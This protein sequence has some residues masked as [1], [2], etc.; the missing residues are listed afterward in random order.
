MFWKSFVPLKTFPLEKKSAKS[1]V[2]T[3]KGRTFALAFGDDPGR[4]QSSLI[5][6]HRQQ[7][8]D[9][10]QRDGSHPQPGKGPDEENREPDRQSIP[11]ASPWGR[12][13]DRYYTMKSLIL[14][15]DE[16]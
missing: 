10:E 9:R 5:D 14:A 13:W 4:E 8:R 1:L 7:Q 15:Q 16:R 6:L 2:V 11:R 12:V 3:Q